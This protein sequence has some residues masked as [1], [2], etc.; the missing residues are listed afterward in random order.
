MRSRPLSDLLTT[1][2][3]TTYQTWFTPVI[4]NFTR[5]HSR[6]YVKRYEAGLFPKHVPVLTGNTDE[7]ESVSVIKPF[8]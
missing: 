2:F 3:N 6:D 5:Y 1:N 8:P 4:D 7:E